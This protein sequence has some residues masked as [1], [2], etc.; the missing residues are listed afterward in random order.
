MRDRLGNV[1]SRKEAEQQAITQRLG[2]G[3]ISDDQII[4]VS[5]SKIV[6]GD[7][8]GAGTLESPLTI[9]TQDGTAI[10]FDGAQ[11]ETITLTK[12]DSALNGSSDNA[13]SN[14]VVTTALS[15]KADTTGQYN[16]LTAG[17]VSNKITFTGASTGT[18]DGSAAVTINIP[19]AP[20]VP[21]KV[22][23]LTNDSGFLTAVP[24]EY[25]T[26]TELT[27]KGY[28]TAANVTSAITTALTPY[29][30]SAD[31]DTTYVKTADLTDAIKSAVTAALANYYTKTEADNRFEPKTS[32]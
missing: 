32:A 6:G 4:S 9:N 8:P 7:V 20:V 31:A 30:K 19:A 28:Q 1:Y 29:L 13:V 24:A 11:P 17:K 16:S 15:S 21:I 14:K 12:V 18:F 10:V 3:M 25:V 5:A 26:D 22:S 2:G 23:E 27:A